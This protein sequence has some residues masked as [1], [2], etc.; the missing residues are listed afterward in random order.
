MTDTSFYLPKDKASRL[1]TVYAAQPDGTSKRGEGNGSD[2]QGQY[3]DGPRVAFS[4]GGGLLSTAA[5]YD[6]MVQLLL[7]GGE[8]D[9]VRLLSPKTI[10]LMLSNQVGDSY[11]NPGFGQLGF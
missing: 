7:N 6:R 1:A 2:A 10:Q 5:D 11:E 3:I 4:G 9:G 8:L